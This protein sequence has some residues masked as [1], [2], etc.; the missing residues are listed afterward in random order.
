MEA[1]AS[2]ERH[3]PG[4]G[5]TAEGRRADGRGDG[6]G[7]ARAT[8]GVLAV[9]LGNPGPDYEGTRHN[10]GAEAVA[11]L[12]AR[13][14]E[15]LRPERGTHAALASLRLAGR[16]LVLAIP[17]TYMNDSGL[18]LG[19][20]VRRHRLGGEGPLDRLVVVHD[21]L[22]LPTGTVRVKLGGGTAGHNGLRSIGAHLHRL[23]FVR[24]R[25]GIGRPPGR[26]TGADYV[27]RRPTKPEREE[28]DVAIETAADAI[29][30]VHEEGVV[31][32]MNRF[33]ARP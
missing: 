26:M 28:L 15:R 27:L 23:D 1:T 2:A 22:D 3:A 31:A 17:Q 13:Y 24:I 14:G 29:V 25:I 32:A 19:A 10:V 4:P 12:A 11:R 5:A 18:A 33:N 6:R 7:G 30:V 9:G 21:E 16:A 8:L 20:L